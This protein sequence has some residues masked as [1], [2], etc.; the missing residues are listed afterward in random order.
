MMNNEKEPTLP[1]SNSPEQEEIVSLSSIVKYLEYDNLSESL[2]VAS[3]SD[4][5]DQVKE[6]QRVESECLKNNG[7]LSEKE[8]NIV[9][10][11]TF[12]PNHHIA[13]SMLGCKEGDNFTFQI[14]GGMLFN[15]KIL[16]IFTP[17]NI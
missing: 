4:S 6:I 8:K 5:D 13:V 12:R 10:F 7:F 3:I 15:C 16:K 2:I 17:K 9:E 14:P 11:C 1:I